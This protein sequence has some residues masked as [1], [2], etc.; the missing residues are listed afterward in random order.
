MTDGQKPAWFEEVCDWPGVTAGPHRFGGTEFRV[1][2]QEI[3]HAHGYALVDIPLPRHQRDEAIARG[4]A[5]PHHIHP[6]SHW[7]SLRVTDD[8]SAEHA[9]EL[10]RFN[11]ERLLRANRNGDRNNGGKPDNSGARA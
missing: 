6:D 3:G 2:G 11:Y 1:N 7:V 5:S 10:L 4:K 8:I 9:V